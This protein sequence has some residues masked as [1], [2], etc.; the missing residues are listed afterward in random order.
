[1]PSA[2]SRLRPADPKE[3][4]LA[5]KRG[6]LVPVADVGTWI[7]G[8]ILWARGVLLRSAPELRDRPGKETDPIKWRRC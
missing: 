2:G 3:L 4:E 6:E 5:Q 8:M 7:A 1:M